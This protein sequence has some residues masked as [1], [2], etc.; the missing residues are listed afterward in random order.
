MSVRM[1]MVKLAALGAA[2]AVIGGGAVHMAEQQRAGEPQY[3]KHTADEAGEAPSVTRT[4]T[5][6]DCPPGQEQVALAPQAPPETELPGPY[7]TAYYA[8][9]HHHHHRQAQATVVHYVQPLPPV[10]HGPAPVPAP[11]ML[12]LFG[13][14]A[15]SLAARR[16]MA[17]KKG[18]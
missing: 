17:A 14:A 12:L 3:I 1:A 15:S 18:A 8:Q 4:T 10:P 9:S 16:R 6:R 11:P 2:G 5:K 7:Y 13:A